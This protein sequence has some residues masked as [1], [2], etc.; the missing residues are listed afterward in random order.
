MDQTLIA[1]IGN[2]VADEVLWHARVHP[3]RR[4]EELSSGER[5]RVHSAMRR[6]LARWVAGY[7]SLP[8]GWLIHARGR[9]DRPCPRCGTLLSRTVV[10]GRTTYFCQRCQPEAA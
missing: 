5:S 9:G 2:L 1:G 10:G 8:R 6:V 3:A 4:I 7:G